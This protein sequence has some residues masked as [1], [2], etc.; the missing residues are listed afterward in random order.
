LSARAGVADFFAGTINPNGGRLTISRVR[1]DG[2][3]T[4]VWDRTNAFMG[5]VSPS[6]DSIA[7]LVEQPDG[8]SQTMILPAA[9]GNGR[10]ILTPNDRGT[11]WSNDGKSI[12]YT[13][14]VNG[15]GDIGIFNVADGTTRRLTTTPESEFS[16]EL[17]PDGKTMLMNRTKTVQRLFTANLSKLVGGGK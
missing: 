8:K 2:R 12:V 3:M 5:A 13:T 14:S 17:T 16:A 7:A 11:F 4:T 15:A 1:P 10:L 9:G 6:G